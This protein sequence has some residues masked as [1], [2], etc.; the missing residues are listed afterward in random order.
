[1]Q[2]TLNFKIYFTYPVRL[3][4]DDDPDLNVIAVVTHLS[5]LS[6]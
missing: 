3:H 1:M 6:Y 2:L 4:R 5:Y